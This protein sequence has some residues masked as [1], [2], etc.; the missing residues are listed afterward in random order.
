MVS[1][2]V[3]IASAQSIKGRSEPA[4][5]AA[6]ATPVTCLGPR[7]RLSTRGSRTRRLLLEPRRL[8]V[9]NEAFH[10]PSLAQIVSAGCRLSIRNSSSRWTR[11]APFA[12]PE[13]C[14]LGSVRESDDTLAKASKTTT[15]NSD[16]VRHPTPDLRRYGGPDPCLYSPSPGSPGVS[17]DAH[18]EPGGHKSSL[19]TRLR[20]ESMTRSSKC[21]FS[22]GE[23]RENCR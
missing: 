23:R 9:E 13:R 12:P 20:S 19:A 22:V 21:T 10:C 11:G 14:C 8:E 16:P 15:W 3:T 2:H 4:F 1:T 7:S 18:R 6:T 17:P 5:I